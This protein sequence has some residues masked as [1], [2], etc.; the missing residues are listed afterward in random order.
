MSKSDTDKKYYLAHKE[1]IKARVKAYRLANRDKITERQ[2][3]YYNAN[4]DKILEYEKQY[5][6]LNADEVSKRRKAY[7]DSNKEKIRLQ[8]KESYNRN[9]D[10]ARFRQ[11]NYYIEHKSEIAEKTREYKETHRDRINECERER[12]Y[13]LGLSHP[14]SENRECGVFLGVYIAEK[15]L[16]NVFKNVTRMS[17]CNPGYDFVCSNG[18]KIDV[19][20]SCLLNH[21]GTSSIQWHFNINKNTIADYFLLIGFDNRE[22][23][24]PMR[25]WL[26]PGNVINTKIGIGVS[27]VPKSLNRWATYEKPITN[28][29]DCCNQLKQNKEQVI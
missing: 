11:H 29:I 2:K 23:L 21:G 15:V 5:V 18:Y 1:E 7:R 26:V 20:S 16:S 6:K 4:R 10:A 13:S 22:D 19:K 9:I 12:L 28:V 24:N 17:L 14:M 27:N 8:K 3:L 25:V